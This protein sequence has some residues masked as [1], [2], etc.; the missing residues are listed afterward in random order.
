MNNPQNPAAG[1]STNNDPLVEIGVSGLKQANGFLFEEYLPQLRGRQGIRVYQEMSQNDP[2]VGA[3]LR[4]L[5]LIIA[6]VRWDVT[7][8]DESPEAAA[9]KAFVESVID[10]MSHTW[11]DFISEV[12]TM[13]PYGFAYQEILFKTRAD[14]DGSDPA[15]R[16]KYPDGRIGIRK[17]APRSQDS[18][19]RWEMQQDG[20]IAGFHQLPIIGGG[21]YYIPI[22]RALLFRVN[23]RKN[24]PESWSILRNAY[25][26]WYM[27]K[28]IEEYEAIGI[29]RELVGLP[30]VSIPARYLNSKDPADIA[31]RNAYQQIAR[32]IRFGQQSGVVIP[33][34]PFTDPD[35]KIS[36]MPM[37]QVK[38]L[39]SGGQRTIDTDKVIQRHQRGI[40][41]SVLADF[42]MVGEGG[43]AARGSTSMHNG[44][45]DLFMTAIEFLLD[46]IEAPINRFLLPRLWKMNNL[47]P[48]TMPSI[49]HGKVDKVD[50]DELGQ[51]ISDLAG[52][53]MP[54][55]PDKGV[56]D[57]LR[58][59]A[60][61]PLAAEDGQL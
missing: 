56:E 2:I 4:A 38:L 53:G 10:D 23:S 59:A 8:A 50:L 33:S 29:E 31:V 52:A 43:S 17:L 12:L 55:F 51:Y 11:Q 22:E 39:T 45:V 24:S 13:L 61:L 21:I 42:L 25:R 49:K 35:G 40:A 14:R 9:E 28:S 3:V 30:V 41:K 27:L 57:Y 26:P 20:G 36:T 15:R 32:D 6:S 5:E 48:E 1:E 18:L 44:K 60:G 19:L 34:D 46:Q 47:P 7:A 58:D 16:T 54:L 37:V